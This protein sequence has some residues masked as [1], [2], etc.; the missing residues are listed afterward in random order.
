MKHFI[1]LAVSA[2][3]LSACTE[4]TSKK[5]V[6]PTPVQISIERLED[7]LTSFET[8]EEAD[9]FI[10]EYS[11]FSSIVLGAGQFP[12][13]RILTS[14]L[15]RMSGDPHLDTLTMNTKAVFPS[16][17]KLEK[18]ISSAYSYLTHYY[19]ETTIPKAY[20]F[21]SGFGT[22]LMVEDSL[23]VIGLD[24]FSTSKTKFFPRDIPAYILKYY[25][26]PYIPSKIM[27][28]MSR[29]YNQFD[30]SDNSLLSQMI[31]YGKAC[32]FMEHML[33]HAPDSIIIEY[34]AKEIDDLVYTESTVWAHFINK[35][36]FFNDTQ[37]AK[38]R[39]ID[40]RPTIPEIADK[41]PGRIGRWLGWQIVR[42][43]MNENQALS[44][45][46]LMKEKNANL[47]FKGSK[48][49]PRKP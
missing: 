8:I 5:V 27:A 10:K 23:V 41:C 39:Y 21:V 31:Y 43:Y 19:P 37:E 48:Y 12:N 2:V 6:S 1:S 4:Q 25:Q 46:E 44:L 26:E 22:E 49:R 3:V 42:A 24:F 15:V 32:Y 30:R 18:E 13:P 40:E 28:L 20:T 11:L 16:V 47:I 7:Q 14:N 36:L 45:Q 35:K 34:S 33:P 9:A 29:K 38:R 17:K